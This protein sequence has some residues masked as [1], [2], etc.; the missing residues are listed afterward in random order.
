MSQLCAL[1]KHN[2]KQAASA[3]RL[4]EK[5]SELLNL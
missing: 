3:S 4:N 2:Q 5:G 1:D